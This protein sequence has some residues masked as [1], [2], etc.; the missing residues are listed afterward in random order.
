MV[1]CWYLV[2]YFFFFRGL[3]G[4][5]VLLSLADRCSESLVMYFGM[6]TYILHD[7]KRKYVKIDVHA[8]AQTKACGSETKM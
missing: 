3:E 2:F 4:D 5:V 6:W 1:L 7:C 8:H